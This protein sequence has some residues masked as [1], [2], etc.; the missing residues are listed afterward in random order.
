M[1]VRAPQPG[2]RHHVRLAAPRHT[3][4]A[5]PGLSTS[6][7]PG[8]ESPGPEPC[9]SS[10][11][12]ADSD[13]LL[14]PSLASPASSACSTA[15]DPSPA[16]LACAKLPSSAI[17]SCGGGGGRGPGAGVI[18]GMVTGMVRAHASSARGAEPV[19]GL[20]QP[21]RT[22][23]RRAG[24]P[25]HLQGRD[26]DR[27][28]AGRGP[29]AGSQ[30]R[31]LRAQQLDLER[32]KAPGIQV[33]HLKQQ[34]HLRR[35]GARGART[36]ASD[37]AGAGGGGG[38][39]STACRAAPPKPT[40]PCTPS[41]LRLP[42]AAAAARTSTEACGCCQAHSNCSAVTAVGKPCTTSTICQGR[43]LRIG[44]AGHV[45]CATQP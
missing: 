27:D 41:S 4:Q 36:R 6:S 15:T 29:A 11:P 38:G 12:D 45:G 13:E 35:Q 18:A 3:A 1:C 21:S 2:H 31:V 16:W 44:R 8:A 24:F 43:S 17:K 19:A 14:D 39:E 34:S 30:R 10:S 28:M 9:S 23:G 25:P 5:S 42:R 40:L 26:R 32:E 7:A 20:W 37:A 22:H 33:H